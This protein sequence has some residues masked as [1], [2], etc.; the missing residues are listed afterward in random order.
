MPQASWLSVAVAFGLLLT[1]CEPETKRPRGPITAPPASASR[2]TSGA[3]QRARPTSHIARDLLNRRCVVCH[4]CYDAPCQLALG[5]GSGIARGASKAQVYDGARLIAMQPTRLDVDARTPAEWRAR[6]FFPV[7]PEGHQT[8]PERSLLARML[9][10]KRMNPLPA[11]A[12]LPVGVEVGLD[13]RQVCPREDEFDK[14]A[15]DHR[16]AGMPYG[17]PGLATG[18]HDALLGWLREGAPEQ[19]DAPLSSALLAAVERWEQFLNQPSKKAR[20]MARYLYEHLF[21]ASLYFDDVEP[22]TYFRLVRSRSA[23]GEID[24]LATRRPFEDPGA[25]PFYYRLVRRKGVVLDKTHMPYALSERRLARYRELFLDAAYGVDA[26]PGYDPRTAANPFAAF[27]AIPV[28]A[29]YRFLLDDAEFIMSNF[30]KGPV[31]RGQVALNVIED[32]F[33]VSFVDPASPIVTREAELLGEAGADLGLPAEQG[34]NNLFVSWHRYAARQRRYVKKKIA[35]LQ[36]IARAEQ[37]VSLEHVWRGDG[38][39]DNAALTIFRNFDSATVH[40]GYLGEPPKSAW[41]VGYA[42][43]ERIHYLLVAGFDVFGNVGHQLHTRMYMDFLRMEAEQNYVALLPRARRDA[44]LASWYRDVE[45]RVLEHLRSGVVPVDSQVVYESGAPERELPALLQARV[46]SLAPRKHQIE[47]EPQVQLRTE[48]ERLASVQGLAPA[49]LPETSFVEVSQSNGEA[50]YFTLL[51]ESAH[52][53]VAHLF[54]EAER[55]RP[56]E[57]RLTVLRGLVGA[58]PNALFHVERTE[59]ASFVAQLAGVR[60]ESDYTILRDRFGVR[61]TDPGF[62]AYSDRLHVAQRNF[63]GREAGL[64]DFNRL[65]DR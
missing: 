12:R 44:L 3:E 57:D 2:G 20:L 18:E 29:R 53:N 31:C 59:F 27:A 63:A 56:Q 62:W 1:S 24:E 17:L 42:L 25:Q 39:N 34:S 64:F 38:H 33:W 65:E 61:R 48:L 52:S 45:P 16:H 49:T 60:G 47:L 40:N 21:L 51:R 14:F 43:F 55:R 30:I 8:N 32:R 35:Y 5:T 54:H 23:F 50:A 37:H 6:G 10:L 36:S 13:R 22:Q 15:S 19:P 7:L 26:L 11:S 28:S 9:E 58:Y 4:G 46:A 41:L